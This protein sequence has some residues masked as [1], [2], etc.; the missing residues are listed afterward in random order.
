MTNK[1][2]LSI[3][4]QGL[5]DGYYDRVYDPAYYWTIEQK[6]IYKAGFDKARE[7]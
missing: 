2:D 3:Y 6:K 5:T 4:D 7:Y 1:Q